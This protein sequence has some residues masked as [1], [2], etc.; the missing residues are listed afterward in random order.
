MPLD[1]MSGFSGGAAPTGA[2]LPG[3]PPVPGSEPTVSFASLLSGQVTNAPQS[4]VKK[5]VDEK[6]NDSTDSSDPDTKTEDASATLDPSLIAQNFV[7]P[8]QAPQ[9]VLQP[10]KSE[11]NVPSITDRTAGTSVAM[12]ASPVLSRLQAS[13]SQTGGELLSTLKQTIAGAA[14]AV[15]APADPAGQGAVVRPSGKPTP[16]ANTA[17]VIAPAT[18]P[19]LTAQTANTVS[20]PMGQMVNTVS[21]PT[22]QTMIAAPAASQILVQD[23]KVGQASVRIAAQ[24]ITLGQTAKT[25]VGKPDVTAPVVSLGIAAPVIAA[26]PS[27]QGG[28]VPVI[29]NNAAAPMAS[30]SAVITSVANLLPS[31]K[32]NTAVLNTSTLSAPLQ[33]ISGGAVPVLPTVLSDAP[34][35]HGDSPFAETI[36]PVFGVK[37][38]LLPVGAASVAGAK[39]D[40][41]A[42]Q[43]PAQVASAPANTVSAASIANSIAAAKIITNSAPVVQATVNIAPAVSRTVSAAPTPKAAGAPVTAS[44]LETAP[45]A[46]PANVAS[47]TNVAAP[48]NL[49]ASANFATP[50]SASSSVAIM[51][52]VLESVVSTVPTSVDISGKI[53]LQKIRGLSDNKNVSGG[54]AQ[55]KG[56][57]KENAVNLLQ[58]PSGKV[59]VNRGY[60]SS[61]SLSEALVKAEIT[62]DGAKNGND[63][64]MTAT[65]SGSETGKTA[66]M[67][68]DQPA[69]VQMPAQD[70]AAMITKVVDKIGEMT[71]DAKGT[72]GDKVTLQLHPQDWG[73]LNLTVTMTPKVDASGQTITVV[74]AHVAAE[75]P[76]V[77]QALESHLSDLR[78]SLSEHGLKL[79][80]MTVVVDAASTVSAAAQSSGSGL[81]SDHRQ[82]NDGGQSQPQNSQSSAQSGGFD[83]SGQNGRAFADFGSGQFS[84]G[85]QGHQNDQATWTAHD[86]DLDIAPA[87]VTRSN[88]SSR[89]DYRA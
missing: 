46:A 5:P 21:L 16:A 44:V 40:A 3:A 88:A 53:T 82:S 15:S 34:L 30:Q 56:A 27:K 87:A 18:A 4:A 51:N 72:G 58:S 42:E 2:A 68:Q 75:N 38:T 19:L 55:T 89:I 83:G 45:V 84:G 54:E 79:D 35:D 61:S 33:T 36:R 14:K 29:A 37:P 67:I 59:S 26:Q 73:Q 77:K 7:L 1:I 32:P 12:D 20:L 10:I 6:A 80:S 11:P 62:T 64:T 63:V 81:N 39:I 41:G 23:A 31:A 13:G 66:A 76:V 28:A 71:L 74:T 48:G 43:S 86:A 50:A 85:R 49:L 24:P 25:V 17:S 78:R 70:R 57:G 8:T 65:L 47:A 69:T 60:N 52:P 9:I 22:G